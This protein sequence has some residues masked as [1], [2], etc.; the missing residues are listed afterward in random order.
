MKLPEYLFYSWDLALTTFK[1]S[2]G[3]LTVKDTWVQEGPLYQ[4][5]SIARVCSES[6]HDIST[7]C[8]WSGR[9]TNSAVSM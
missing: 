5:P 1:K 2:T 9:T 3:N 6:S 4:I 7:G 8:E